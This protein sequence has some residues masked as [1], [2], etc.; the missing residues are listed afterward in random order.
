[1]YAHAAIWFQHIPSEFWQSIKLEDKPI[2]TVRDPHGRSWPMKL[3]FEKIN[4]CKRIRI[5]SGWYEFY[6]SNGLKEGDVCLFE[7][8]RLSLESMA[9]VMNARFSRAHAHA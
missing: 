4:G 5:C 3:K 6:A 2:M 7:L 8:V 9:V 1:M